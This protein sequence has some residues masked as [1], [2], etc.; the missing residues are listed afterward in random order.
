MGIGDW[1]LGPIPNP[2]SPIPNPQSPIPNKKIYFEYI[3]KILIFLSLFEI[4]DYS[5]IVFIH[6]YRKCDLNNSKGNIRIIPS[7]DKKYIFNFSIVDY[8][9]QFNYEKI[10]EQWVKKI[11]G[12]IKKMKDTNFSVMEPTGY[13]DRFRHFCKSIIIDG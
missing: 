13:G 11:V 1:G 3:N 5:L 12:F 4:T 9:G 2:Q 7:K 6:E 8:L 10:G